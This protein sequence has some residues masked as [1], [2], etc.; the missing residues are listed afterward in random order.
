MESSTKTY[1]S[2]EERDEA[3]YQEYLERMKELEDSE[4]P[5]PEVTEVMTEIA[6]QTEQPKDDGVEEGVTEDMVKAEDIIEPPLEKPSEV[7]KILEYYGLDSNK[8]LNS[9]CDPAF[10]GITNDHRAAYIYEG[11]ISAM[12]SKFNM[13]QEEAINTLNKDLAV[14]GPNDPVIVYLVENP[15]D[16]ENG[17]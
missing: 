13:S 8:C 9:F 2:L 12:Q 7:A 16:E 11:L 5:M 17:N 1:N 3:M 14:F 15:E 10:I 6:E 4:P